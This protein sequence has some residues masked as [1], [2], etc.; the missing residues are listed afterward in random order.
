MAQRPDLGRQVRFVRDGKIYTAT[1]T[2]VVN[3]QVVNLHVLDHNGHD[4]FGFPGAELDP[5]RQKS[6]SWHWPVY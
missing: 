5:A 2:E 3:D 1:I 6:G 4:T